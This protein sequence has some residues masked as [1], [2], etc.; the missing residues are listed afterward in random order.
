MHV[1]TKELTLLLKFSIHPDKLQIEPGR[2]DLIWRRDMTLG[3]PDSVTIS[4]SLTE[5]V[6]ARTV[7]ALALRET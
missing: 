4:T 1:V 7:N 5:S 3:I 6:T 2:V